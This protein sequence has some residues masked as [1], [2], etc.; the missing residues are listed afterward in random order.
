ME[1][2]GTAGVIEVFEVLDFVDLVVTRDVIFVVGARDA[3]DVD[4]MPVVL[5]KCL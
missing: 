4:N 5:S 1:I 2:V 3:T